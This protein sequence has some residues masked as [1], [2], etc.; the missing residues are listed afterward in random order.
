MRKVALFAACLI[1]YA[2]LI[3]FLVPARA[4]ALSPVGLPKGV[5]QD[6]SVQQVRRG[7]RGGGFRGHAFG[8]RGF[9]GH[10]FRG[11]GFRGPAFRGYAFR[12]PAFRGRAFRGHAFRGGRVWRGG[13]HYGWRGR[14]WRRP[15]WGWGGAALATAPFFY[16]GYY[17]R[18]PLVR[19]TVWTPR[20]YRERWVRRC[21]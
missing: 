6:D 4:S 11:R 9:R 13:R 19:R 1:A 15:G 18:C 21:W 16:G 7:F 12:G 10:A 14:G 20:G 8:G 17:G 2:A 5:F 3:V